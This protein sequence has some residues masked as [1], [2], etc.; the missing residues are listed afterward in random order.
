MVFRDGILLLAQ[1]GLL[2]A[3]AIDDLVTKVRALDMNKV[4]QEVTQARVA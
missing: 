4:R 1:P 3:T 2:P